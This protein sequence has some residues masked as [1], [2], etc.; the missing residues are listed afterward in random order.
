MGNN[1]F[2]TDNPPNT[3]VPDTFDRLCVTTLP[4][5]PC[6]QSAGT[7]GYA[8]YARS[9]H[10]GGVNALL[11]DGSARFVSSGVNAAVYRALG[12]RADGEVPGEF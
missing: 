5:A 11:G 8:M 6:S 12:S 7:T 10:S 1:L 3:S 9:Y 4:V 2:S